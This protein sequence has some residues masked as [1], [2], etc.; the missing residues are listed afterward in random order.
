MSK[1]GTREQVQAHKKVRTMMKAE[2]NAAEK[3]Q[4]LVIV[5]LVLTVLMLMAGLAIDVGTAY[6]TRRDLQNAADAGALAGAQRLCDGATQAV[7]EDIAEQVAGMNVVT[8][9]YTSTVFTATSTVVTAARDM[10]VVA[11]AQ[12]PTYFMRLPPISAESIPV[13]TD[14]KAQCSCAAS[15]GGLW[16][17]AFDFPTWDPAECQNQNAHFLVWVDANP[18]QIPAAFLGGA[19]V[20][21]LCDCTSLAQY[22]LQ[23][24]TKVVSYGPKG[25][26]PGSRGWLNLVT[27]ANW[28]LDPPCGPSCNSCGAALDYWLEHDYPQDIGGCVPTQEGVNTDALQAAKTREGDVVG[29]VLFSTTQ[30]CIG[31][32]PCGEA[33]A[34]GWLSVLDTGCM[35]I[36]HVF[37]GT[38]QD[39]L[40]LPENAG[41]PNGTCPSGKAA[42]FVTKQCNCPWAQG[43][44]GGPYSSTCV[45]SVSLVD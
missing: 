38:G 35:R 10:T 26:L 41:T 37:T 11:S 12:A 33:T 20:C 14:A 8:T 3:G 5:A 7:A 23:P 1:V 42:I 19:D 15:A 44:S 30:T 43:S 16:P 9:M 29:L 22:A 32:L 21:S 28:T 2:R 27:P 18:N 13:S 39:R 6:N 24:V 40:T 45:P 34:N 4:T 36:N 17:I 25:L 31:T